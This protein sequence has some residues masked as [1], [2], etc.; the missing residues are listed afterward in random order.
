MA[1]GRLD[2]TEFDHRIETALTARYAEDLRPLFV[3]LPAPRPELP[4]VRFEPAP[5]PAAVVAPVAP[6]PASPAR[7]SAGWNTVTAV[8][9]VV[10][11]IVCFASG[12]HLWWLLFV[13]LVMGGC[14]G[15]RHR[16]HRQER[17]ERRLAARQVRWDAHMRHFEARME[18]LDRRRW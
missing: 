5:Q 3:D 6:K 12:W 10:A 18:R 14:G 13:P 1:A 2:P 16:L 15:G 11:I 7:S 8:A 17:Y 9:W 4:T